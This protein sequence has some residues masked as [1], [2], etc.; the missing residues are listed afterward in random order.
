MPLPKNIKKN[1]KKQTVQQISSTAFRIFVERYITDYYKNYEFNW[2]IE[3]AFDIFELDMLYSRVVVFANYQGHIEPF[4]LFNQKTILT[5]SLAFW[6]S[7]WILSTAGTLSSDE[8]EE[9]MSEYM[10]LVKDG[11]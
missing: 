7:I 4:Y 3:L 8:F 9:R 6:I 11:Q 5:K 1:S 10:E 2:K